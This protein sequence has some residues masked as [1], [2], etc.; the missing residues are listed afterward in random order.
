MGIFIGLVMSLFSCNL[1]NHMLY[2][3]S[4]SVPSEKELAANHLQFWP[5][6]TGYHGFIGTTEIRNTKGTVIVFHGNAGTADHRAYYVT[7]LGSMGYRVILAEYPGYGARKGELGEKSFVSDAQAT[8]RLVSQSYAEPI[9]LLGESLGCGVVAAAAKDKSLRIEALILI[10]PWDSLSAVAKSLYPLL[11]VGLFLKDKYDSV[12]NLKTFQG[13]VAVVGAERD[14]ILPIRHANALYATLA[15]EKKMW[16][17]Q[18]AGHNDWPMFV[19]TK[20]WQE[21]IDFVN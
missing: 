15:G 10:T 20:K 16:V 7:A 5:A 17:I 13:K 9:F 19:D 18:G 11:P 2:Y 12:E 6:K 21:F 4:L 1:Q 14:E 8:V 3:P